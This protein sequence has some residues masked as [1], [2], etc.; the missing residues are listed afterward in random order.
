VSYESFFD[1]SDKSR[2]LS[3]NEDDKLTSIEVINGKEAWEKDGD[4][5]TETLSGE[6]LDSR[7]ENQYV[8]WVTMLF[9]LSAK[10]YHLSLLDET[11]LAAEGCRILSSTRS[12]IR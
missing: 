12:T 2:V 1:G 10:E 9:P 11:T 8:N 3:F 7:R 6:K 5:E 4:Q